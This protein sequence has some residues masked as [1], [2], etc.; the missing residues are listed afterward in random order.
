M[1]MGWKDHNNKE[2]KMGEFLAKYADQGR[3]PFIGTDSKTI[4]NKT[5]YCTVFV[6]Y[7]QGRGAVYVDNTIKEDKPNSLYQKLLKETWYSIQ[8]AMEIMEIDPSITPE[9]LEVH[10]DVND[11]PKHKSG[12]YRGELMGMVLA[13]GFE[14]KSKPHSW[15][16]T[17]IADKISR[18]PNK[19]YINKPKIK[20][21]RKR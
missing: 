18:N 14:C 11:N 16:A 21:R 10:I 3:K 7:L 6:Y 13:Q 9:L 17:T 20:K 2:V 5:R 19:L 12:R 15:A 1:N 4:G 8:A